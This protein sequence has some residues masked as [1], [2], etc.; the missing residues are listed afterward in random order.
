MTSDNIYR[1]IQIDDRSVTPKYQQLISSLLKAVESGGITTDYPL[2]SINELSYELDISRDTAE[3][4]YR[5]L[6]QMGVIGSVPGKG[7]FIIKTDISQTIQVFLLFNKLSAHKKIIYDSMVSML[8]EKAA[9]DFYIYNNDYGLFKQLLRNLKTD[10]THCVIIPHFLE[11]GELAYQEIN[12]IENA[13]LILLDKKIQGINR[14]FGAVYENFE[15]DIFSALG[16]AL[17]A[18]QRYDTIK[19]IFPSYTYFPDEILKGFLHF[20]REYAFQYKVVANIKEETISKGEVYINLME[21]DLVVLLDKIQQMQWQPGQDVGIISYNE[22]PLKRFI[23]NGIT[24]I[25]TDFK[26]MGEATARMIID[27]QLSEVE[28]PFKL[29]LRPSL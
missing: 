17:P 15:R 3:K 7:Y 5:H 18:L 10:Y 4:A 19:I 21:E 27:N 23:L 26:A 25:S 11:G 20:C 13:Q 6:K 29:T 22:T 1:Y 2:P 12:A 28:V 14:P 9:I 24:T 8:G 16:E